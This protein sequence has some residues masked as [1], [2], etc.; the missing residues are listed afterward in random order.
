MI[1]CSAS[2]YFVFSHIARYASSNKTEI[3][4]YIKP[5]KIKNNFEHLL[6]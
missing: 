2:F 4:I 1:F 6:I 5:F 3:C